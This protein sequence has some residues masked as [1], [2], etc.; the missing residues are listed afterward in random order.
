MTE[1]M[2]GAGAP[3]DA[4]NSE[5]T[6]GRAIEREARA[7]DAEL[8]DLFDSTSDLI[9]SVAPD[10]SI[11]FVNR[12]WRETLGYA[13][14]EL[15]AMN[16][17]DMIR[18]DCRAQCSECLQ[19]ILSGE[20][21]GLVEVT[22]CAK[23]GRSVTVEGRV[24]VRFEDGKAVAT[25]GIF[26][27]VTERKQAEQA[28]ARSETRFRTLYDS[29]RDAV[30]LLDEQGFFDCNQATLDIF[31]CASRE[32]FSSK[33]PADLS[34]PQQPC[35]TDS[36][37]LA[38]QHI[39]TAMEAG[40]HSFE[41]LHRRA[42][43]G[44]IFPAEVLLSAMNLDGK[45]VLQAVV[46]DITERKQTLRVLRENE[47]RLKRVIEGSQLGFWDHNVATNEVAFSGRWAGMLGYRPEEL[48]PAY[49]TWEDLIHPEDKPRVLDALREHLEGRTAIF[50]AE[51][52][53]RTKSGEWGWILTRGNVVTRDAA[54]Q[55]LQISGIHT[56]IHERKTA[57]EE[58][59]RRAEETIRF[60][61]ALL[62]LREHEADD[63]PDFLRLA[64]E[65]C[66]RALGVERVGI[67]FFDAAHE[68]IVCQDLF[69]RSRATH[70]AGEQRLTAQFPSYFKA[71]TNLV[72]VVA[73]DAY[74][75][76]ATRELTE[77]YLKPL[78][79]TS[80]LDAPIR[81]G[82]QMEGVLRCGHVGPAREW[83]LEEEEFVISVAGAILL[84]LENVKRREAEVA[85]KE[86]NERVQLLLDSTAEG[87]YGVDTD[88]N[89]TFVNQACL[90]ML[91]Y[92]RE[93]ELLGRH[94]HAMIHHTRPDGSPYP[95]NE[96]RMYQVYLQQTG[97]VHVENEVFWRRDGTCFPVAYW[98][99]PIYRDGRLIGAV[100]TFFDITERQQAE[101]Q[102][103]AAKAAAEQANAA[104]DTFLATM[105][106][107]I[108]TQLNGL[109]GMLE[110]LSYTRLDGEQQVTLATA[111]DSGDSLLQIINDVLDH[112]KIE[113]G[114]LQ[115]LS[116]P[117]SITQLL[118]RVV[119]TYHAVAS[120]KDLMLRQMVDPRINPSLLADPLRLFQI[121]GNFVSNAIK[122]TSEGFVEVRADL[123]RRTEGAETV[124]LSVKDTGIGIAP[125]AQ[126]RLFQPF[127]QAS[128]DTARLYGGTGLGLAISRRLAEMMGGVM[129]VESVPGEGTTMSVTLTLPITAAAPLQRDEWEKA[130]PAPLPDAGE[131]PLALAVDDHPT[132]RLLL[133]Q[134]LA[135]LGVRVRTA[136]DGQEALAL[137]RSGGF[138]VVIT[139]CNMPVMDGYAFSRAV[140]GIESREGMSRTPIIAWTAN[141]LPGVVA[142]CHAAGMDDILHKPLELGHLKAMLSKY[143][144]NAAAVT[145]EPVTRRKQ[146]DGMQALCTGLPEADKAAGKAAE[147]TAIL[148]D[149][150]AQTRS[151]LAILEAALIERDIPACGRIAHHIAGASGM[152]GADEL[153]SA[154]KSMQNAARKG[155]LEGADAVKAALERLAAQLGETAT[156]NKHR[157]G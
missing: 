26:R 137:W 7:G 117:V 114:K 65:E 73:D 92:D 140:R 2:A 19:R 64:T 134:Q 138:A 124:R 58:A 31:G 23:D 133:T 69:A 32:E 6:A 59:Q 154:C 78:G 47:S 36:L 9:Q 22:F 63:L 41:W 83:T 38:M 151:D 16:V 53:L 48:E 17:F 70:E 149:F 86:R 84:A 39:V 96:C 135:A 72:A 18:A 34:P 89:C 110:L 113:A 54:G 150:V 116:E 56:D 156:G 74:T 42:D 108:R 33:H 12:A 155:I 24:N 104:K 121:L 91:G 46:R 62:T 76:P 139:D 27:D 122:F 77:K 51:H 66:A 50:E 88:G 126:K 109:L 11:L 82:R 21:V 145:S 13:E 120:A 99:H 111:R 127:E 147:R 28:L 141:V 49:Q 4:L 5:I 152:V 81:I 136:K 93:E 90:R 14:D 131:G 10:G 61:Q 146:A 8:R 144:V 75:H 115:I 43:T 107:E 52:R 148:R 119:N 37:T 79:I 97:G 85:L 130:P 128:V 112:A 68:A 55:P 94:I 45:P 67:W 153:A 15:A 3:N 25:R 30:M 105:S 102:L 40:S 101:Q 44:A 125:E 132:N 80:M 100:A 98:S 157:N 29:N 142:Q 95:S 118:T 1:T 87:I 60:Q 103:L 143:L 129:A 20:D 71:I 35:G 106:H 57:Q 123:V